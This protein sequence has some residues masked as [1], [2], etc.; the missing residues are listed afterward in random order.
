MNMVKIFGLVLS[1][2]I[3]FFAQ[4][5][6]GAMSPADALQALQV[7]RSTVQ[8]LNDELDYSRR[9]SE[10]IAKGIEKS[11]GQWF[12]VRHP[13]TW[14]MSDDYYYDLWNKR[15]HLSLLVRSDDVVAVQNLLSLKEQPPIK[16]EHYDPIL[17]FLIALAIE[18]GSE[19]MVEVLAKHARL[20]HRYYKQKARDVRLN[21]EFE[22]SNNSFWWSKLFGKDPLKE[23][24]VVVKKPLKADPAI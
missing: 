2:A 4:A 19:D 3:G 18:K 5:N 8:S 21:L 12:S 22:V 16:I 14:W 23:M 10:E 24:A 11:L 20:N 15:K 13:S 9:S 1:L 17:K 6:V 7:I